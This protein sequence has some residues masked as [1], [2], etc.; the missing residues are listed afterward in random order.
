[1]EFLVLGLEPL[2]DGVK[3]SLLRSEGRYQLLVSVRPLLVVSVEV[4]MEGR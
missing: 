3:I 4:N 2:G 1:M